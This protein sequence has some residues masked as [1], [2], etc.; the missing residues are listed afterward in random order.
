MGGNSDRYLQFL[1]LKTSKLCVFEMS[2]KNLIR[3]LL[4]LP[5]LDDARQHFRLFNYLR[6]IASRG[7]PQVEILRLQRIYSQRRWVHGVQ[8]FGPV[9]GEIITIRI[10]IVAPTFAYAYVALTFLILWWIWQV[11]VPYWPANLSSASCSRRMCLPF[12]RVPKR[13]CVYC[14][15]QEIISKISFNI[16]L[17]FSSLISS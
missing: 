5:W 7:R 13:R 12:S 6:F 4:S 8:I 1:H 14:D 16:N 17:I 3:E 9:Q 11:E 15:R 2:S 10:I